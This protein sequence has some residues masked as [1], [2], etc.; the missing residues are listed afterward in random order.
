MAEDHNQLYR[1][2]ES[3]ARTGQTRASS[4]GSDPLAEL[5]R[6]IGQHDPF[7]D[8]VNSSARL[9][10]PPGTPPDADWTEASTQT[11]QEHSFAPSHYSY[12]PAEQ[13]YAQPAQGYAQ[14][15]YPG[16]TYA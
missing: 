14:E 11:H 7:G 2:S 9:A 15:R 4:A 3:V 10:E 13:K 5:A 16:E 1:S 8:V 6:L 12:G